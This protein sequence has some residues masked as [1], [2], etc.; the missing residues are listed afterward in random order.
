MRRGASGAGARYY[1]QTRTQSTSMV[2]PGLLWKNRQ[3]NAGSRQCSKVGV[4][5][6]SRVSGGALHL[7]VRRDR[8]RQGGT[9]Q[10]TLDGKEVAPPTA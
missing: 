6:T 9:C 8:D 10:V 2:P 5:R 7:S 4:P 1:C 3:S